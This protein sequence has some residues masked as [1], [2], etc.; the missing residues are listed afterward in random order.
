MTLSRR[1]RQKF[2][3]FASDHGT[4]STICDVYAAHD[5]QLPADFSPPADGQ[6]RAMCAA[7]EAE[8]NADDPIVAERLLR[9][10]VD[11]LEDW[12]W[13]HDSWQSMP[14]DPKQLAASAK[15]LIS[16]LQRDGA[17]I[18]DEGRLAFGAGPITVPI[19]GLRRL[20]AP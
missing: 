4:L 2:A 20:A 7:L 13:V 11:A 6:R 10:Y 12:G 8:I 19:D 14:D 1:A 17:A 16:V 5:F 9:V 18:D 3:E 15:V